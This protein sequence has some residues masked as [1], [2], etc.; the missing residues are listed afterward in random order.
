VPETL[1][2][3]VE[4]RTGDDA[5]Y[6]LA[7]QP[8]P[9]ASRSDT[10][11]R[12][13]H[14]LGFA[15]RRIL[16]DTQVVLDHS[17]VVKLAATSSTR[18]AGVSSPR[19]GTGGQFSVLVDSLAGKFALVAVDVA[20]V[21]AAPFAPFG[22]IHREVGAFENGFGGHVGGMRAGYGKCD[23]GPDTPGSAHRS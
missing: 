12:Q 21:Q 17:H 20:R 22:R 23:S 16:P 19:T 2:G 4:D 9:G 3:L 15:I 11:D 7:T 14:V 6:R 1:N 18:S 5:G 10:R 13:V 8:G